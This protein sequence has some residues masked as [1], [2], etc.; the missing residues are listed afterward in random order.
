MRSLFGI[1]PMN[2]PTTKYLIRLVRARKP[3]CSLNSKYSLR[4]FT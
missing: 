3:I 2:I 4:A 1:I